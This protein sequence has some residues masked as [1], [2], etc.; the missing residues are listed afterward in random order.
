MQSNMHLYAIALYMVAYTIS[1]RI[2]MLHCMK[3]ALELKH[4][5]KACEFSDLFY[6]LNQ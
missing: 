2:L 1:A 5:N 3:N 4:F 6:S